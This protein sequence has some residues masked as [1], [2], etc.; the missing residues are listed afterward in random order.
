MKQRTYMFTIWVNNPDLPYLDIPVWKNCNAITRVTFQLEKGGKS[1]KY[2]WQCFVELAYPLL[3]RVVCAQLGIQAG[4]DNNFHATHKGKHRNAG[5]NY[6]HKKSTCVSEHSKYI[7][8][9]AGYVGNEP[10]VPCYV[11]AIESHMKDF[12]SEIIIDEKVL[13]KNK[14]DRKLY[15]IRYFQCQIDHGNCYWPSYEKAVAVWKT[16][17]DN[18]SRLK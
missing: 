10:Q 12:S 4:F 18:C 1:K 9:R 17:N 15:Q 7:W 2:H 6:A 3:A 11:K 14:L 16:I 8:T 5:R 13:L